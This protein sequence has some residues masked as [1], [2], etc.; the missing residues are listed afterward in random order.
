LGR[1]TYLLHFAKKRFSSIIDI[2]RFAVR[3]KGVPIDEELQFTT[4]K[5]NEN[6][7]NYSAWHNR[8]CWVEVCVLGSVQGLLGFQLKLAKQVE[9][10]LFLCKS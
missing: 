5:I 6:F 8:R 4:E 2:F 3:M 9:T 1:A 7:S 10:I